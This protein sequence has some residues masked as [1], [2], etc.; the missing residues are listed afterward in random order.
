MPLSHCLNCDSIEF[1]QIDAKT[2]QCVH[3]G[4]ILGTF[5]NK[6]KDRTNRNNNAD[7]SLSKSYIRSIRFTHLGQNCHK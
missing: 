7:I 4:I 1:E 3:C 6:K 5:L 2:Y